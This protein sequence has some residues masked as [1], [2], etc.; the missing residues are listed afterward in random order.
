[1]K[2]LL[3]LIACLLLLQTAF[4]QEAD[5]LANEEDDPGVLVIPPI[6]E[7]IKLGVKL[8]CGL[9]MIGGKEAINPYPIFGLVGGGYFRYRF[10]THWALQTE[11]NISIRGGKFGNKVDEYGTIRTYFV[12]I[13][14][15]L[16]YGLNEKNTSN[17]F[18]G[19]QYSNLLNSILFKTNSQVQESQSPALNKHDLMV[20]AGA[21]FHTPFVGFQLAVKYGLLDANKGL[22]PAVGPANQGKNLQ[23]M[24]F[25]FS[26]IY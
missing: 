23:H 14:V 10:N 16:M 8:G 26:F 11:T 12:D 20:M 3:A 7:K 19:T 17:V 24:A 2:Y 1:M 4:A 6:N 25:E 9:F 13:P 22:L 15:L 5:S 18:V 21:Q